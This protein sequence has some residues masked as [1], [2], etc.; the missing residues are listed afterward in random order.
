MPDNGDYSKENLLTEIYDIKYY[1]ENILFILCNFGLCKLTI[2]G[3][4][5]F[6][7]NIIYSCIEKENPNQMLVLIF[8][9]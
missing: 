4:D 8:L 6:L 9:I 7:C 2:E 5:N 3:K 1:K